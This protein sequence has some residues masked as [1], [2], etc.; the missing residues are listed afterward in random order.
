MSDSVYDI[1]IAALDGSPD[2]L[3]GLDGTV[4]L[5]FNVLGVAAQGENNVPTELADDV[6]QPLVELLETYKNLTVRNLL[7]SYHDAQQALDLAISLFGGGYLPLAQRSTAE[8][9][10]WAICHK[11]QRLVRQLEFVPEELQGLDLSQHGEEG[12]I[13]D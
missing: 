9:L 1:D 12:Y 7:E 2:A 5:V 8:N 6:E 13:L 10:Y 3:G 11:I 4:T